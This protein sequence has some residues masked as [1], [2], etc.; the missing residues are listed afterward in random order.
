MPEA[1]VQIGPNPHE[2]K[3]AYREL[4]KEAGQLLYEANFHFQRVRKEARGIA[5]ADQVLLM[6]ELLD[7]LKAFEI[8]A[9]KIDPTLIAQTDSAT[10]ESE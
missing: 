9:R 10:R 1:P 6:T 4:L 3:R 5:T 7:D 2:L 8:S